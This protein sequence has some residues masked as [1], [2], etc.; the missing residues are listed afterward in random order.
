MKILKLGGSVL[1]DKAGYKK[2]R[3][4]MIKK[5]AGS[6]A[7][8]WRKGIRDLVLVHGAGS[9]G[10][11]V[12]IKHGIQEGITGAGHKLGFADTHASCSDL[13]SMLVRALIENG[14]PAVS[15]PPAVIITLNNKRIARFDTKIV[16]DY[17]QAGYLP[18]LFGDMAPDSALGGY[19]CS[20]DQIVS[21]LGKGAE[22]V[23]LATDVDGVMDER[24]NMI[25]LISKANFEAVSGHLKPTE[26]DVTGGMK[27]KI[28]E[29]LGL[30]T[31][32][33]IV[34][35]KKPERIESLLFGKNAACTK[36][37]G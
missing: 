10:H 7:A 18:V 30:G 28:G 5:L 9:F 23:I 31:A 2:A 14:A 32:S 34:N 11:A 20:G 26:N 6:V 24:G 37:E 19:P 16:N 1:T 17:L 36:I 25:P 3:P 22:M 12:V 15:I 27:G 13:S 21:Y 4:A 33:Y 35:A 8:I 29:L